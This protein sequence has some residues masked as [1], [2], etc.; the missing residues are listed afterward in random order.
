M[1]RKRHFSFLDQNMITLPQISL[2]NTPVYKAR[3]E[4]CDT[5]EHLKNRSVL[6]WDVKVCG[7]CN[8]PVRSK[9]VTGP[10]PKNLWL[11]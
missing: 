7:A 1:A 11:A 4:V 9:C 6:G 5:C 2:P 10:C 3:M 8:C